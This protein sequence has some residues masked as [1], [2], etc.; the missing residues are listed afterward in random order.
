L[1]FCHSSYFHILRVNEHGKAIVL[2]M[3]LFSMGFVFLSPFLVFSYFLIIAQTKIHEITLFVCLF[4]ISFSFF[5]LVQ[6]APSFPSP[7][8]V[9]FKHREIG[10]SV[11]TE[12]VFVF[13]IYLA[14]FCFVLL[15]S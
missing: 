7:Y 9:V 15:H 3:L 5:L 1:L 8:S 10:S 14:L 4:Q 6:M 12:F 13:Y 2:S 11:K